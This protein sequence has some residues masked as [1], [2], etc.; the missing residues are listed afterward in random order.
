MRRTHATE[1]IRSLTKPAAKTAAASTSRD[2]A[3]TPLLASGD[4]RTRYVRFHR[5]NDHGFVEFAFGVGSP[6][7]M[8]ELIMPLEQYREFCKVNQV[9]YLTRAEEEAMDIDQAKWR[10]GAPGVNE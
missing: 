3:A 7:L 10:Y 8:A 9:V 5:M 2:H 4:A 1:E 6:D